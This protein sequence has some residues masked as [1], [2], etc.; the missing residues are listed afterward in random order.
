[1]HS[2][3]RRGFCGCV[4]INFNIRFDIFK[5]QFIHGI[6]KSEYFDGFGFSETQFF[7][8]KKKRKSY[9]MKFLTISNMSNYSLTPF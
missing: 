5:N 3:I 1:M 9:L 6:R 7:L 2:K 4:H 8:I